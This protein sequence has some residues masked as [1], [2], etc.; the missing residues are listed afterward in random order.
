MRTPIVNPTWMNSIDCVLDDVVVVD[1]IIGTVVTIK[2]SGVVTEDPP[3]HA[4]QAWKASTPP[5]A[6]VV[7]EPHNVFQPGPFEPSAEH[8]LAKR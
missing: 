2:G 8:Q 1:V 4:Q 6:Y 7:S 3:P 5:T